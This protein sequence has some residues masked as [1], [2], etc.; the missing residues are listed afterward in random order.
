MCC[1]HLSQAL[2]A[3]LLLLL[4]LLALLLLVLLALLLSLLRSRQVATLLVHR[5]GNSRCR[6]ST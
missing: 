5:H 4:L 6:H 2:L 3:L 1:R